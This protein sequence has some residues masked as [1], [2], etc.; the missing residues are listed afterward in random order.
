MGAYYAARKK[1]LL[2][3]VCAHMERQVNPAG[4][5]TKERVLREAKKYQT[6]VAFQKGSTAA[7]Q[8]AWKQGWL[9]EVSAHMDEIRK[10]NGY[11]TLG[12]IRKEAKKYGTRTEFMK[13]AVSAYNRAQ[14]NGWL[15]EVCSH[16][17]LLRHPNGYWTRKR[18]LDVARKFK[19]VKE[20]RDTSGGAYDAAYEQ[21]L[22]PIIQKE[23]KMD[24]KPN[25]YWTLERVSKEAKKCTS[26]SEF[27]KA[28]SSAYGKARKM[29]WLDKVCSHM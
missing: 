4:Y 7:H 26:R 9:E 19:T 12:R 27:M 25:G 6:R 21:G 28:C 16:M 2:D 11:W 8:K 18:I 15:D 3:Q 22:M 23:L 13:R 14:K 24:K 20:F 29:G 1:G 17:N 10:P 5:W